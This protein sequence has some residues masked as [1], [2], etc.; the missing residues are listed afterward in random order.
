V[1][2]DPIVAP[3][4][5]S[6]QRSRTAAFQWEQIQVG[7]TWLF[8]LMDG[9]DLATVRIVALGWARRAGRKIHFTT[10]RSGDDMLITRHPD[11]E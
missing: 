9:Y 8:R 4:H 11:K 6:A 7:E 1:S 2:A 10:G 3:P 5:V